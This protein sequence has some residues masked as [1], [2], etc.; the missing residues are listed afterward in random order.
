M[1][2]FLALPLVLLPCAALA[3]DA[4]PVEARR[5]VLLGILAEPTGPNMTKE[6]KDRQTRAVIELEA[7]RRL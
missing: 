7:M 4:N 2:W 6:E 1:K 5:A 3:Q